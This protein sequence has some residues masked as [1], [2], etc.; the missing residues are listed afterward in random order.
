MSKGDKWIMVDPLAV[1]RG[2]AGAPNADIVREWEHRYAQRVNDDESLG[3]MPSLDIVTHDVR[4]WDAATWSNEDG[5]LAARPG[6]YCYFD[7]SHLFKCGV[8]AN[9]GLD[10]R[11]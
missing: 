8:C 5:S 10:V 2:P 6:T 9:C 1:P 11:A 3:P 7:G 4:P